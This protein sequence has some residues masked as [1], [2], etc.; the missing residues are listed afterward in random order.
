MD[1]ADNVDEGEGV[2]IWTE[3]FRKMTDAGGS[4]GEVFLVFVAFLAILV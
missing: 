4:W 1:R 3:G 2:V